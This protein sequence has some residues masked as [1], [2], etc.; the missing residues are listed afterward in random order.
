[1]NNEMKEWSRTLALEQISEYKF[2]FMWSI[3]KF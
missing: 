2:G 3:I 1:M